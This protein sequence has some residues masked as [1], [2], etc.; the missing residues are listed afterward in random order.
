MKSKKIYNEK[1]NVLKDIDNIV[2]NDIKNNV[3]SENKK[4]VLFFIFMET[5][6]LF[7][8]S[9]I[10]YSFFVKTTNAIY[11]GYFMLSIFICIMIYFI[12][13]LFYNINFGY[14]CAISRDYL[15]ESLLEKLNNAVEIKK[16]KS[17]LDNVFVNVQRSSK[18]KR[19]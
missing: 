19:L 17:I 2:Y 9:V 6:N 15:S 7:A 14:R 11:F 1:M 10:Y 8:L 16:E 18:T 3:Y 13:Y 5:I 4:N 12:Y